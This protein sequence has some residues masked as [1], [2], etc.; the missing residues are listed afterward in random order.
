[1]KTLLISTI[2]TCLALSS[3][4]ARSDDRKVSQLEYQNCGG[5]T[6]SEFWVN[7]KEGDEKKSKKYQREVR[8]YGEGFGSF[9]Y[10]ACFDLDGLG[11]PEGSEVWLSYDI[12]GGDH[13]NCRKDAKLLYKPNALN[14]QK[15]KSKGTTLNNNRCEF[16]EYKQPDESCKGTFT[17]EA[18]YS[19]CTSC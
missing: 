15:Y 6:V 2:V 7:W 3:G 16:W 13:E 4:F 8:G 11:I 12:A 1:M 9:K 14:R 17:P 10:A 18:C 19:A 5:Y